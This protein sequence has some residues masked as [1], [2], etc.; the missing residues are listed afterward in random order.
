MYTPR[1]IYSSNLE[2]MW[3]GKW[4]SFSRGFFS[5]SMLSFQGVGDEILPS[6]FLGLW[7]L[8]IVIIPAWK[9]VEGG[10]CSWHPMIYDG[11]QKYPIR[12]V[13]GLGI[14]E[15]STSRWWFLKYVWFLPWS[16][17]AYSN[18]TCVYVSTGLK[19]ATWKCFGKIYTEVGLKFVKSYSQTEGDSR[20]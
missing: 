5:G 2:M 6:S 3:F 1:K 16:L 4:F 18:L 7:V 13:V 15:A 10:K 11:F 17:G 8:P 12:K 20:K 19:P 14:S 9:P